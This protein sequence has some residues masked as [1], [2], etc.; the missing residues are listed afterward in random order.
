MGNAFKKQIHKVLPIHIAQVG[1][2]QNA[3]GAL[4]EHF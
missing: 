3:L 4:L 1:K 2:E